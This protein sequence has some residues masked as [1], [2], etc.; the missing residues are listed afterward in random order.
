MLD[1]IKQAYRMYKQGATHGEVKEVTRLSDEVEL[2]ATEFGASPELVYTK[3]PRIKLG[4]KY[5]EIK[6]LLNH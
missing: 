3:L 6:E 1:K 2:A 5:Q 4:M